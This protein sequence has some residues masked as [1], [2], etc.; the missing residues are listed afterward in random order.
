MTP[1]PIDLTALVHPERVVVLPGAPSKP[2]AISALADLAVA[3]LTPHDRVAFIRAVL[4]REDV[5]PTAIGKSIAIPHAR[6]SAIAQ[7]RV[8]IGV[9]PA[10]TS[11]GASDGLPVHLALLIAA[12]ESDHAEHLRLMATLAVRLRRP[13][14]AEQ[15]RELTDHQAIVRAVLG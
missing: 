2:L 3:D 5:T 7:C 4:E 12:R 13:G 8:A 9:L 6:S 14:L 10:G 11:W 1:A 15:V